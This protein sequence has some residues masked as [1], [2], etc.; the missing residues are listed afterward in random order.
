MTEG[1]D[2]SEIDAL[3]SGL[4]QMK[5]NVIRQRR[6]AAAAVELVDA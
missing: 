1:V 2:A 5:E 3:A 6:T 4:Q